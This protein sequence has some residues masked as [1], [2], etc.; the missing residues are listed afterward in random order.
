ME[1]TTSSIKVMIFRN[2][3]MQNGANDRV[4]DNSV[5]PSRDA[6]KM[7]S[8]DPLASLSCG[9][10]AARAADRVFEK[11]QALYGARF[12]RQWGSVGMERAHC[13]W[14]QELAKLSDEQLMRGLAALA[15]VEEPPTLPYFLRLCQPAIEPMAAYLEAVAGITARERGETRDWSH[16]A[17][18]WAAVAIGAFDLKANSYAQIRRRWEVALAAALAA[19]CSDA[20]PTPDWRRAEHREAPQAYRV[21]R[22]RVAE[23][24]A[25]V[26]NA[27]RD[28]TDH[29]RW[30]K[31]IEERM[32]AGDETV[33][34]CQA[35]A[36]KD[37]LD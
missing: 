2:D 5:L 27:S 37:A 1:K 23:L 13:L 6:G 15:T 22:E 14:Q 4:S 12:E 34:G 10:G 16:P 19:P 35:R 11:M 30:A 25:A 32:T 29:K 31:R 17:V 28:T 21:S 18:Y 7:A 3:P 20:I 8:A 9:D 33:T 26:K 36:A 24:H